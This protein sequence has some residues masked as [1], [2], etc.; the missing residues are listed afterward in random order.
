VVPAATITTVWA[1]VTSSW[2]ISRASV[3]APGKSP[4]AI[5]AVRRQPSLA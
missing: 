3:V 5:P 4:L 1:G 2:P